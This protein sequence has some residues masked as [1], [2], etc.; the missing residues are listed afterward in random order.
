[1]KKKPE[2]S[3]PKIVAKYED[4]YIITQGVTNGMHY[5]FYKDEFLGLSQTLPN[6]VSY[7]SLHCGAGFDI[8]EVQYYENV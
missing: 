3:E 2:R 7:V 4:G 6:A 8:N 5:A 1:M